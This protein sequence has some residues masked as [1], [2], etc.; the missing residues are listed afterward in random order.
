MPGITTDRVVLGKPYQL[1]GNRIVFTNWYYIQ[2]GDLDWR[3]DTGNSVYVEGDSDLWGAQHVGIHPPR[4]ITIRARKPQVI[5]PLDMPYRMILKDGD[6]YKGWTSSEYYESTDG[7]QWEKK[8]DL[9]LDPLHEDG[10]LHIFIDPIAPAEERFKA[11][12]TGHLTR[13]QFDAFR[14][15]RPDGWEP[16]AVFLLGEQDKVSCLRASVSPDGIAWTTLPEPLVVEYC[17]TLNTA[18]YDVQRKKYVIYTRFWSVGPAAGDWP[19]DIR[20]NWTGVGRRAIGRTES[21]NFREFPPSTMILEPSPDMLPSEQLYTNSYTTVPGAPDQH[22]MF[23]TLWNASIDDTTRITMASSHDGRVWHWVPGGNLLE[24]RPFGQWDGGCIW[25]MPDLVELGNGDWGLPYLGHNVSHKYPR[26]IRSGG[27]GYAV[28]PKGRMVALEAGGEGCFT[29]I[30]IIPPGKTIKLNAVTKR[31]GWIKVEVLGS[32]GRTF[33]HCD[34]VIGDRHW[35][36]ISWGGETEAI[37][38]LEEPVTLT[39]KLYQAALYGI[40]FE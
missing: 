23:P 15:K 14:E 18:Y 1:L 37:H 16:K 27:V 17:D 38:K 10:V 33:E 12:W 34:P 19:V 40:E 11:V 7:L 35:T 4:G 39:F 2:P 25:G 22:L 26:G 31:T 20:G 29:M 32:E 13:A 21:D 6:V 9:V 24:T 28:W 36:P 8:A 3:D 5:G 30:P